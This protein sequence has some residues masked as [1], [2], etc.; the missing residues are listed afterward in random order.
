MEIMVVLLVVWRHD[1]WPA[2]D[3]SI[4]PSSSCRTLGR[5]AGRF[6]RREVHLLGG[7]GRLLGGQVQQGGRDGRQGGRDW[8]LRPATCD[9]AAAANNRA[10]K[11]CQQNVRGE[12]S[13]VGLLIFKFAKLK[14]ANSWRG[15]LFV[16]W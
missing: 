9:A 13:I 3:G 1:S 14:I 10:N 5:S 6:G 16:A 8:L 12:K 15:V 4:T 2:V 11:S 7:D